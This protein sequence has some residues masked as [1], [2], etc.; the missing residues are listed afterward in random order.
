MCELLGISSNEKISLAPYWQLFRKR[1]KKFR[2]GVGN[3]DGWGIAAYP[4]GKGALIIKEAIPAATS[5]LSRFLSAYGLLTSK[6]IIAHVRKANRGAVR[7]SNSHPFS[8][9]LGGRDYTF[10]HNG[11][12]RKSRMLVGGR[13]SPLGSTDSER[14]FCSI[15]D[16]LDKEGIRSWSDRELYGLRDFLLTVNR[17]PTKDGMKPNKINLLLSEGATLICYNDVFGKG[18][19]HRLMI[20]CC[21]NNR[22]GGATAGNVHS[23]NGKSG[24]S[25]I[26]LATKPLDNDPGWKA[27]EPGEL[28]AFRNGAMVFSSEGASADA[29]EQSKK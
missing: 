10:A 29:K 22:A 17:R 7:F 15:L 5:K 20:P 1:G 14:L 28:C 8:R 16:H 3:P 26:I 23:D 27:M 13:F 6:T 4:D 24:T 25:F 18:T 12:V 2:E 19:L 21:D 11:T 9:V